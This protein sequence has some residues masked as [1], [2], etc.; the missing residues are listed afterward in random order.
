MSS[1]P[2]K[3]IRRLFHLRNF[4]L[5]LL[6]IFPALV[7]VQ[8]VLAQSDYEFFRPVSAQERT[9]EYENIAREVSLLEKQS[10]LLKRVVKLVRP[11]V[12][13]INAVT[14]RDGD[15]PRYGGVEEAGAGVI[16]R[17][18]SRLCVLTNRH[19]VASAAGRNDGRPILGVTID[20]AD[21]REI[22]P[23]RIH[24]HQETDVAVLELDEQG[25]DLATA[26]IG[27]SDQLEAG[28]FVL[29]V[30]S[31]FALS[32]SFTFGIV[33]A[34][35]RRDLELGERVSIQE[36]IQIDAAINPGNSGGPLINLKGELVGI[37]TAIASNS[38]GGEGV[39][40]SIPINIVMSVA[41]QLL[42]RGYVDEGYLG[43]GMDQSFGPR[44]AAALG[45]PTPQGVLI[46]DTKQNSPAA[47]AD[48]RSND[49]I[50]EFNGV[51]VEDDDHLISLVRL[52]P[53]GTTVPVVAFRD[54]KILRFNI[55]L[56]NN[57]NRNR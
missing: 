51:R 20:L 19:V 56:N 40:F 57:P 14:A 55:T 37:N 11:S 30:G 10:Q 35:G 36:F 22:N 26:R 48:L 18:G 21:R 45:L 4:R 5:A 27:D 53:A 25:L 32:H 54:R 29:A 17:I 52:T 8:P 23:V 13:H 9:E 39:G 31:P 47:Q 38:G 46:A 33:S 15:R 24:S 43:V 16:V 28:D 3:L 12:V 7:L 34:M 1:H 44:D 42:E 49:V 6:A 50:L 41:K 2:Q